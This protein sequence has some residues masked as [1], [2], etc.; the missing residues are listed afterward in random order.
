V[1]LTGLTCDKIGVGPSAFR[2]HGTGGG[3]SVREGS[4]L[5]NQVRDLWLADRHRESL[6]QPTLYFLKGFGRGFTM[7]SP[8]LPNAHELTMLIPETQTSQISLAVNADDVTVYQA[9]CD[10]FLLTAVITPFAALSGRGAVQITLCS[11][12]LFF[13]MLTLSMHLVAQ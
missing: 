5:T 3:C 9:T 10:R 11:Q 2:L 12:C 7:R 13:A 4:C 1:D 8:S 6:G